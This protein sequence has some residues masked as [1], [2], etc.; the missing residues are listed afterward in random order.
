MGYGFSSVVKRA[1]VF[2]ASAAALFG[3][4]SRLTLDGITSSPDGQRAIFWS[5]ITP[6]GQLQAGSDVY[7]Y[8]PG[9]LQRLTSRGVH[10]HLRSFRTAVVWPSQVPAE[11]RSSTR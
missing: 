2:I 6:D 4:P 3:Q 5:S 1:V 10:A 11:L 8:G 7:S 9:G